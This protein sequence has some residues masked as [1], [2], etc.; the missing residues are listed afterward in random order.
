V[1][2][3]GG[4]GTLA[5]HQPFGNLAVGESVADQHRHFP[6]AFAERIAQLAC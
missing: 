3:V 4:S 2:N 1:L 6:L 5:D